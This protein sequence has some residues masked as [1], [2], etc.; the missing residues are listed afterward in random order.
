MLKPVSP[1]VSAIRPPPPL[2]SLQQ[3]LQRIWLLH[4]A[5]VSGAERR[6]EGV[7]H[8]SVSIH[9]EPFRPSFTHSLSNDVIKRCAL[10]R[11]PATGTPSSLSSVSRSTSKRS[12]SSRGRESRQRTGSRNSQLAC[13]RVNV[14]Q[15]TASGGASGLCQLN[16][17]SCVSI[18]YAVMPPVNLH[19]NPSEGEI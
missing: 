12:W 8:S 3:L 7:S 11:P 19:L 18:A 4:G 13:K 9:C 6:V 16:A 1:V 2:S 17:L 5:Q 15:P 14:G 10:C